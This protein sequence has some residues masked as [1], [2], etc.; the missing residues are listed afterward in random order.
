M[1]RGPLKDDD[2]FRKRERALAQIKRTL[3]DYGAA[4][5]LLATEHD[6]NR[7][8]DRIGEAVRE[9]FVEWSRSCAGVLANGRAAA[10]ELHITPAVIVSTRYSDT[11]ERVYEGVLGRSNL[12]YYRLGRL[13]WDF[14]THPRFL[15]YEENMRR[16]TGELGMHGKVGPIVSEWVSAQQRDQKDRNVAPESFVFEI[17]KILMGHIDRGSGQVFI[18]HSHLDVA[19]A[20]E[21]VSEFE[22]SGIHCF[23]APRDIP[24]GDI[25]AEDI[26]GAVLACSELL[27]IVTPNSKSS[28]W[29][30]IEA[31]AA[32]AIGRV[33][34]IGYAYVDLEELPVVL[35]RSQAV[36]IETVEGRR[37]LVREVCH[38]L[39]GQERQ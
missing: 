18:S 33:I 32:W 39:A 11:F 2:E 4:E 19:L 8:G 15:G 12:M 6:A 38:R 5:W 14:A 17:R 3:F 21:L 20:K 29:L 1:K 37:R 31:G 22:K 34:N 25:W 28:H 23:L 24:S 10:E 9:Q 16:L 13:T 27:A 36:E 30:M 26:R 7:G 35:S